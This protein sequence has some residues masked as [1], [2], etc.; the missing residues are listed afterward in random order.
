MIVWRDGAFIA[1]EHAIS[2][3]DRGYLVGAAVFETLLVDRGRPAFLGAHLTRLAR[4]CGALDMPLALNAAELRKAIATLA[5]KNGLPGRGACRVTVSRVGGRGLAPAPDARTQLVVSLTPASAAR[6]FM[7]LIISQKRRWAASSTNTFKC[8]GAYAE[9]VLARAEAASRGADEAIML[10]ENG[11]VAC[12][13]AANIFVATAD[14]LVTPP[15]S[16]GA[17]PGVVRGVVLEE[18]PALGIDAIEAPLEPASLSS[19]LLVTNSLVGVVR[20]AVD[21]GADGRANGRANGRASAAGEDIAREIAA[22]YEA[23]L[24]EAFERID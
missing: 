13:S 17:M 3:R 24:A 11:R 18:A 10:N 15:A 14:G 8:A 2:A 6:P 7:K 20:S 4:G 12:A 21:G 5:D 1:A 22:A 9:N 23:R 16:E 19:T